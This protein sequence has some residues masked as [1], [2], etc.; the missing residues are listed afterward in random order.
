[1]AASAATSALRAADGDGDGFDAGEQHMP[2]TGTMAQVTF[3]HAQT[4][5]HRTGTNTAVEAVSPVQG[6]NIVQLC[7]SRSCATAGAEGIISV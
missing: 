6:T 4:Q 5:L 1:M 7:N 3:V 2:G